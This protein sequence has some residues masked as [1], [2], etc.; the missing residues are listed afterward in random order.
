VEALEDR[1]LLSSVSWI[2]HQGGD[3][4]T[5]SDWSTGKVPT[6]ADAVTINVTGVTVTITSGS[7][8]A[9]SLQVAAGSN[10]SIVMGTLTLGAASEIDGG[11]TL[12]STLTL[13]GTLTLTGANQWKSGGV[14]NLNGATL[15]NQGSLTLGAA[16]SGSTETLEASTSSQG[17]LLSNSGTITVQGTAHFNLADAVEVSNAAQGSF[18]FSGDGVINHVGGNVPLVVN[19]GTVQ[20]SGGTGTTTLSIPFSITGGTLE[21]DS[22]TLS[23]DAGAGI[24]TGGT[25]T[26]AQ[27]ATL[28]L[29]GNSSG[30][31]FT[32]SFTG[33]GAGTVLLQSGVLEIGA[34]GATFNFPTGLFQWTGGT[35]NLQGNTLTNAGTMTLGS[36]STNTVESL[37]SRDSQSSPLAHGTFLNTA[38]I[39]QQ[40]PGALNLNDAAAVS[41]QGSYQLDGTGKIA[42][43]SGALV[44]PLNNA[45][46]LAMTAPGTFTI[47][48]T[49][50]NS[51]TAEATSGTLALTKYVNNT[52]LVLADGAAV[53]A[54]GPTDGGDLVGGQWVARDGGTLTLPM[55]I[56]ASQAG[57]TVDGAASTIAGL[58]NLAVNSGTIT[59]TNGASLSTAVALDNRGTITV[60]PAST[61]SI[62]GNCT[63]EAAGTLDVLLGGAPAGGQFGTVAATGS[64][65]L[66]GVLR[67]EIVGGY[68]PTVGDSFTVATSTGSGGAFDAVVLPTSATVAFGAAVNPK[69]ILLTAQAATA[70]ATTTTVASSLPNGAT[71]GQ[72]ITFTATVAPASGSGTPTGTVQFQIDGVNFGSPVTLTGGSATLTTTLAVGQHT[73]AALYLSNTSQFADSEDAGSPLTQLVNPGPATTAPNTT[74]FYTV[75]GSNPTGS[76]DYV[77]IGYNGSGLTLG[78]PTTITATPGDG[79]IILPD[80][81]L[82]VG[83][84]TVTEIDPTGAVVGTLSQVGDHL[85]LDPSGATVWTSSETGS[86]VE[87]SLPSLTA[88][89][90]TITGDDNGVTQLAFDAAGNA[91]YTDS[92]NFGTGDFGTIDLKTF[93]TKRL[94]HNLPAAHGLSYDPYTGDLMLFGASN[95]SQFDPRTLQIVSSRQVG[96]RLDQG[97]VDGKGHLYAADNNGNLIFLD[98]S[99]THLVGDPPN[100]VGV[101][102][103]AS[104]LDDFAPLSGLGALPS[105]FGLT[106]SAN[107]VTAGQTFSITVS[108]QD[109]LNHV[110]SGYTGTVHFTSTDQSAVLPADYTF[111]AADQGKHTFTGVI[112]KKAG[113]RTVSVNDV[114]FTFLSGK[115]SV[116]VN[117]AAASHLSIS[118]PSSATAGSAFSITVTALDPYN[119]VATSYLG[120]IHFT[121][122]DTQAALPADYTFVAGDNGKHT[123]SNS[124]TLN[125]IGTQSVTATDTQTSTIKGKKSITVSVPAPRRASA[126]PGPSGSAGA[127][128]EAATAAS[129]S[130]AGSTGPGL[131]AAWWQAATFIGSAAGGGDDG[132]ATR[133]GEVAAD[134]EWAWLGAVALLNSHGRAPFAPVSSPEDVP[135][136]SGV[137]SF[138]L[139]PF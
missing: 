78:T 18:V 3:W 28:D 75:G 72:A 1:T 74:L 32:G 19:A 113:T 109:N 96:G 52:G 127:A 23:L 71:Y 55:G 89:T 24:S 38:T 116:T 48:A 137:P 61:F 119:N 17:G 115:K 106:V 43:N 62:G 95:I 40:G 92:S 100:F 120:T 97:S 84:N 122:S 98:Y 107:P 45:G 83:G 85:A 77:A 132:A 126:G 30:N 118:G 27:N 4:G 22:G 65:T 111:T 108:A 39:V 50:N 25:F 7:Q 135:D 139:D 2:N 20:K 54:S 60:G 91:Y 90:H 56:T 102:F 37:W 125:T 133:Q 31:V 16:K 79:L 10:L 51:G 12:A 15:N 99:A 67:A 93:A 123:F 103:L 13:G 29:T 124:V 82:V 94:F 104:N 110:F 58:K 69:S 11:L 117:A 129:S 44:A 68:S 53:T 57:L 9:Q 8:V 66:G 47:S 105:H 49:L 34:G 80:E 112:L 121:S 70:T 128:D 64:L 136:L 73:I 33:S 131:G 5:A 130:G 36:A 41:N 101:P 86:L 76:V 21:V 138:R 134:P 35:V 63:Q 42:N 14:I 87:I 26:V 59:V 46:T 88:V 81:N 114:A 6:S